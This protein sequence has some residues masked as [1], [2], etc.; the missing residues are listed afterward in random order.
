ME[1]SCPAQT[2]IGKKLPDRIA[3][4][5]SVVFIGCALPAKD[6]VENGDCILACWK[7]MILRNVKIL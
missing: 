1:I 4:E 7:M 5:I 2:W 6:M 3:E